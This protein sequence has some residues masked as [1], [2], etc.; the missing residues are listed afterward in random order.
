LPSPFATR[1]AAIATSIPAGTTFVQTAGYSAPGDGGGGIYVPGSGPGSFNS[2]DGASWALK[3]GQPMNV[4]MFGATGNGTTDDTTAILLGVQYVGGA[5]GGRLFFPAGSYLVNTTTQ[6]AYTYSNIYLEGESTES[7]VIVNASTNAPAITVGNGVA[8]LYGGGIRSMRFANKAGVTGVAGNAGVLIQKAGQMRLEDLAFSPYPNNLYQAINLN[9]V[10]QTFIFGIEVQSCLQNG[11]TLI[12]CT[13]LY[14]DECRSDYNTGHGWILQNAQGCY[15]VNCSGYHNSQSAWELNSA[16]PSSNP[17]FNNFF[18]NCIG[19][20]SGSYNWTINDSWNST[21][22]NC[23]GS[24]NISTGVNTYA[25]GFI[26]ATQYCQY[27]QF[28]NCQ[29]EFNN[30]HGFYIYDP[31]G[32]PPAYIQISDCSFGTQ[33]PFGNNGNGQ[34]GPGYGLSTS[35]ACNHIRIN[36]GQFINNTTGPINQASSGNDIVITGNPIGYVA[37]ANG[38]GT[39][40]VSS[41][42]VAI[43]HGLGFTPAA[44]DIQITPTSSLAASSLNSYWI[45][46]VSSTT[47]TVSTNANASTNAW[48]F[49]WR[50]SYPGT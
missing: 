38:N 45:S 25:T 48:T 23:W 29:A 41:S 47:F 33:G 14:A 49:G 35:G 3:S 19:D 28:T 27:L 13:D 50:A 2:A 9:T 18:L 22:V 16:S 21:W 36:G 6:W 12:A 32:S 46:A 30:S 1:A 20:T 26:V 44:N 40:A 42:S 15:F 43:T 39:V 11:I 37:A 34:A 24:S 7:V 5:G 10:S 31:G 4:K 17:N 8:Q